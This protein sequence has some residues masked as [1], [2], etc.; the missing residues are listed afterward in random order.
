MKGG[1]FFLVGA[2]AGAGLALL[3]APQSGARTQKMISKKGQKG[4]K[5]VTS[6]GQKGLDHVVAMGQEVA[7]TGK[8]VQ[9]QVEDLAAM[10]QEEKARVARAVEVGVAAYEA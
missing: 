4:V 10:I 6:V 1:L 7:A 3:Y 5:Q 2:G 8:R 9:D